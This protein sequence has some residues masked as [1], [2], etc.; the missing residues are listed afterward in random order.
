MGATT[1]PPG[2]HWLFFAIVTTVLWGVWGALIE[3]PEKAGFPPTLGYCVWAL[4]MAPCALLVRSRKPARQPR[5]VLMASIAGLLG[6]GGQLL[7]FVALRSGPAYVVFPVISLYPALTVLL[8]AVLLRERAG[9]R[10]WTGIICSLPAMAMLAWQ[11]PSGASTGGAVWLPLAL[12]VF[13]AWGIQGYALKLSTGTMAAE[14]VF[15]YMAGTA[16][17]LIPVAVWMTDFTQPV[18]WGLR[19]PPLAAAIQL[20]NSI[21]ALSLVFALRHGKAIVVAPMTALAPVLTIVLS[22][23][24]YRSVPAPVPLAGMVLASIAIYLMAE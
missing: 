3:I 22:M 4:T 11:P 9:R 17:A 12:M 2:R 10:V 8:S 18:N 19:G 13:V 24:I 6:A 5:A 20:L 15:A 23:S 7:L 14:S 1:V 21:G 16:L